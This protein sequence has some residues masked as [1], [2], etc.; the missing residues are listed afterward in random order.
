[1]DFQDF[2]GSSRIGLAEDFQDFQVISIDLQR[3]RKD[4]TGILKGCFLDFKWN[5]QGAYSRC[6]GFT[7]VYAQELVVFWST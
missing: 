6:P 7:G 4:F 5:C 1:M 2:Q 3:I